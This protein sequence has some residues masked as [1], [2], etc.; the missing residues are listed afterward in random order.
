M[1][2]NSNLDKAVT[3][4][5][6]G[7]NISMSDLMRNYDKTDNADFEKELEVTIVEENADGF[8]VDLG[9]KSE[10]II[11]QKEFEENKVP[12]ELKVSVK[13]KILSAC[14]QPVL[15]YMKVIEETK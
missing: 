2:G 15:S 13:V 9:V 7:E 12:L 3:S 4:F 10:G 14:R 5:E 11:P 1:M 6:Y 8:I